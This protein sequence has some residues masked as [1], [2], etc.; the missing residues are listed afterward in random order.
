MISRYEVKEKEDFDLIK[1]WKS[2]DWGVI[3]GSY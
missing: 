2:F 3:N 1:Y